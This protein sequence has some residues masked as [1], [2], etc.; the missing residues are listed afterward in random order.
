MGFKKHY[1]I[2]NYANIDPTRHLFIPG[3]HDDYRH[4][5]PHALG[6]F[7]TRDLGPTSFFWVRGADSPDKHTRIPGEN[8]WPEEQLTYREGMRALDLYRA[9]KPRVVLTHDC[10][11]YISTQ[12]L[13]ALR[14]TRTGQLRERPTGPPPTGPLAFWAPSSLH[15]DKPGTDD[16]SRPG[17]A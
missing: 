8:W 7:G 13:T 2:L 3:N 4:L 10:P 15:H 5:P 17:R 1:K 9:V 12:W 6:H 16:F 14:P 11:E